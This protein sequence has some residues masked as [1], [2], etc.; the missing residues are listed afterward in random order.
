MPQIPFS[1]SPRPPRRA[2]ATVIARLTC[3]PLSRVLTSSLGPLHLLVTLLDKRPFKM[4]ADRIIA[5]SHGSHCSQ[6]KNRAWTVLAVVRT[7]GCGQDHCLLRV[8]IV[9]LLLGKALLPSTPKFG[10]L[11][12]SS[13]LRPHVSPSGTPSRLP[14]G[15]RSPVVYLYNTLNLIVIMPSLLCLFTQGLS[16]SGRI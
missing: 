15:D 14:G 6:I 3:R 11:T 1:P 5:C 7:A 2:Q 13:V 16:S 8:V 10:S 12:H 9:I 4:Q